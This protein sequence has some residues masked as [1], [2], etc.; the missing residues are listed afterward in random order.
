MI[1]SSSQNPLIKTIKQLNLA[2]Y[3]HQMGK[4]L[5]VGQKIISDYLLA[6]GEVEILVLAEKMNQNERCFEDRQSQIKQT[7]IV[8]DQLARQISPLTN[9]AEAM[10]VIR[11]PKFALEQEINRA[12]TEQK[13]LLLIDR[14]QD[15]GN[16][17][18]IIRTAVAV[19][20][21]GVLLSAGSVD[22]WSSKVIRASAGGVFSLP[23]LTEVDLEQVIVDQQLEVWATSLEQADDLYALDLRRP[24]AWLMGNEGQGVS[25]QL[26]S[27]AKQRV[28]IPQSAAIESLNLATATAV[29]L[30]EQFRQ[31]HHAN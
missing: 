15:P 22:P 17:G 11:R 14:I 3:R 4:S 6:G 21:G 23:I 9:N 13:S 28:K 26:L 24:I 5:I 1:I 29:C 30:Y 31:N 8:T 12:K 18:N 20:L 2:K 10:A 19:G 25:Q 16:L 7:V 27:L